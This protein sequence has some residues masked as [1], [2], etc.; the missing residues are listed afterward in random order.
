MVTRKWAAGSVSGPEAM[1]VSKHQKPMR[2]LWPLEQM[3]MVR[4]LCAV[5]VWTF[6]AT[7]SRKMVNLF[8]PQLHANWDFIHRG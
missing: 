3:P 8:E 7:G 4:F 2:N 5:R 6:R 1:L